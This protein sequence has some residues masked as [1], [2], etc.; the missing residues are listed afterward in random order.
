MAALGPGGSLG[1]G[2]GPTRSLLSSMGALLVVKGAA[3]PLGDARPVDHG[4]TSPPWFPGWMDSEGGTGF[5][6]GKQPTAGLKP[7]YLA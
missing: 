6:T 3:G 1:F 2:P 7:L 4:Q 5:R